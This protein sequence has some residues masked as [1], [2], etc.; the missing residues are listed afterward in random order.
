[1][2]SVIR[3][4]DGLGNQLFQ[5]AFG[6]SFAKKTGQEIILDPFFWGTSLRNYQLDQFQTEYTERFVSPV[7]DYVLGF[8]P[9]NARCFK[10]KYRDKKIRDQLHLELERHPMKFDETVYSVDYPAYF[11]GF[12]QTP[13]YFDEFYD[14]LRRQFTLKAS[15]G[16]R[17][18]DYLRQMRSC[19]SVCL[20]IRRTDYERDVH[21]VCLN[22]TYYREALDRMQQMTGD[23]KLFIFTDD[24]KF[25]VENFDLHEYVMVNGVSD[26][27]EFVLMQQCKNHIIA[28]S[29]FSWWGAYLADEKGGV[30]FAPI[31][32]IW[33]EEFYPEGWNLIP[34][35]LGNC[36]GQR[37]DS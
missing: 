31:T 24:K 35:G 23:F 25:A 18:N 17:A 22:H 15:L 21:S 8:G 2:K 29:T 16:D 26:L 6:Y 28:N 13:R 1:M 34:A 27:E 30:V 3:I 33:K 19:N 5:Y 20:H 12:W 10:E 32:D 11:Q 36:F 37:K 4:S 9:R 14:E 7:F